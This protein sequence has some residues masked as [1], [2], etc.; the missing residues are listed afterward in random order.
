MEYLRLRWAKMRLEAVDRLS[1][2]LSK[3]VGWV[4]CLW[5]VVFAIVFLM[6]ALALWIGQALD[7][8]S[9]GFLIAGGGFLVLGAALFFVGR[10][11][12]R[13]PLIRHF[14]DMFFT[15]ND[16]WYGTQD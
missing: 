14:V 8:P 11:V 9:L 16:E 1:G 2:G 6:V 3:V 7:N 5:F 12:V 13:G 15:S 4:L 10:V